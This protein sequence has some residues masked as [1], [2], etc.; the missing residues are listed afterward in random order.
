M[1]WP[2]L[3][4][5]NYG[6]EFIT[7]PDRVIQFFEMTH[8]FRT[9][10][11]DGRKLPEDPPEPRW[12]GWN[13][14]HWEGNIFVVESNGYDERSW[15]DASRPADGGWTHS[16]DMRVVERYRRVDYSTLESEVTVIDPKT[17]KQ[18]WATQKAVTK[19]VPGAEIGEEFCVPS[20][21]SSFNDDYSTISGSKKK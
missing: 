9:I 3:Y 17:Y 19:L 1:G 13:V 8:T 11:T 16:P 10:W 6:F 15:L 4:T 12:L 5:Y 14:G 7:L 20:D 18:P 21:Y 2:R